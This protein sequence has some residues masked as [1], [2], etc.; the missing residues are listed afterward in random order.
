MSALRVGASARVLLVLAWSAA[1][2]ACA[3]P[4]EPALGDEAQ[5][6]IGGS[7][8][9]GDLAVVMVATH[10]SGTLIADTV[11]L[12]AAHCL[13]YY[14]PNVHFGSGFG[15]FVEDR[16]V[17][18]IIHSRY[19][20][21]YGAGG[22]IALLRLSQPAPSEI[23][24]V[25]INTEPFDESYEGAEL[26]SIGFGVTDGET[27]DGFG[28]KR[29]VT[30]LIREVSNEHL[31]VGTEARNICNG[32]SGGPHMYSRDG[33]EYVAAVSSFGALGCNGPSANARADV[34][35]KQFLIEVIDAWSG[36]CQEDGNC[37]T[38]GCR[39]P[40]PDCDPC[41]FEGTCATDCEKKDLDCPISGFL[42]D[43]CE[44]REDCES[45]LCI[46]APEDPRVKYCSTECDPENPEDFWGCHPPL[47][48]CLPEGD[49][50]NLCRFSDFTPGVQGAAC[51][52]QDECRSGYCFPPGDGICAEQC[53]GEFPGCDDPYICENIGARIDAC[54]LPDEDE[55]CCL[56]SAGRGRSRSPL[57]VLLLAG[58]VGLLLATRKRRISLHNR[59]Q[60]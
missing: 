5:M 37:V 58:V 18:E 3:L 12:T 50:R 46:E 8:D 41:G 60:N 47:S 6:I 10:C 43:P 31:W 4:E 26:R 33:T 23:V 48:V 29:Q 54:V 32:D 11:V 27:Q 28:T 25:P 42:G 52:E 17:S 2:T 49:G 44:T 56:A 15:S 38:E 30:L 20:V 13:D 39:T 36:P 53:G 35:A 59:P 21:G 1:H 24:P 9:E 22:D 34:Y 16:N 19:Y 51:T 45:L 40:D 7:L 57:G 14:I 55:G